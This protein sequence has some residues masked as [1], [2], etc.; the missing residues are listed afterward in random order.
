M[1]VK[2]PSRCQSLTLFVVCQILSQR[3]QKSDWY[4][5]KH[6]RIL[7]HNF[8]LPARDMILTADSAHAVGSLMTPRPK[9]QIARKAK[10]AKL[11]T[12]IEPTQKEKMERRPTI[13]SFFE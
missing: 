8:A 11:E 12:K 6:G 9:L 2:R 4:V 10:T 13:K 1:A 7:H 3:K 5:V